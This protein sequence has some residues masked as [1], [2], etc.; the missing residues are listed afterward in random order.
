[1][2][3]Y[4][5]TND[6]WWDRCGCDECEDTLMEA[7]N[8]DDTD[9]NLGSASYIEDCYVQAIITETGSFCIGSTMH[10][11]LNGKSLPELQE[12]AHLMK[13]EVVIV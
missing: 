4:K 10:G 6:S 5:F 11:I 13:V 2:K 7:Y 9:C 3:T 1:M 12:L 8:S